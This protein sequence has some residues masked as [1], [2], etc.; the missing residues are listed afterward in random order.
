MKAITIRGID[1]ELGKSLRKTARENGD[2][3]NST[4]LKLLRKSLSLDKPKMYPEYRDLDELAGTWS[5]NDEEEFNR[6]Q[7][8]FEQIDKELWR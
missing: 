2:S 1:E 5:K 8:G 6:I 4:L 3:I 7:K